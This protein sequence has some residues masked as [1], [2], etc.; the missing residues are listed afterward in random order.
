MDEEVGTQIMKQVELSLCTHAAIF[1]NL[2]N[3]PEYIR[4]QRKKDSK[5][6][7]LMSQNWEY[8]EKELSERG[9]KRK[10]I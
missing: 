1:F 3:D 4:S 8:D 6:P 7:I 2:Q 10:W 9:D 5:G